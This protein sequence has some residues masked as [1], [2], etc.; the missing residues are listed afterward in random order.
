MSKTHKVLDV[1]KDNP[2][3]IIM[4]IQQG[5]QIIDSEG[6][7]RIDSEMCVQQGTWSLMQNVYHPRTKA[8]LKK[9]FKSVDAQYKYDEDEFFSRSFQKTPM[10]LKILG[11]IDL[12][13]GVIAGAYNRGCGI[14][15]YYYHLENDLHPC[16]A[17]QLPE[18]II[19]ARKYA[20][21]LEM[22]LKTKK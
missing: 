8:T 6:C 12:T 2:A 22:K 4:I 16:Y 11:M 10:M 3:P 18:I 9:Y 5:D 17:A 15:L 13:Y 19:D 20:Q 1:I 21:E 7:F 14:K